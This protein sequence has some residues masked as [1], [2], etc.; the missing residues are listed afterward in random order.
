MVDLDG[1]FPWQGSRM[2][3]TFER[4]DDLRMGSMNLLVH[5]QA[6]DRAS[7]IDGGKLWRWF[8]LHRWNSAADKVAE[9]LR[10]SL[11]QQRPSAVE[12]TESEPTV[13]F[14]PGSPEAWETAVRRITRR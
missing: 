2:A 14:G 10:C 1:A 7:V 4:L 13:D 6:C 5:C 3:R 11:C 8:A 9:H 12:A